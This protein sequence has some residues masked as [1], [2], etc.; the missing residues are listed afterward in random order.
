[1]LEAIESQL[2]DLLKKA[3]VTGEVEFSKPPKS[4]M[5]D[6][7]FV[8]FGL[9]KNPKEEAEKLAKVLKID[10]LELIDEVKAFGPYVNFFFN[11]GELACLTL[12]EASKKEYGSNNSGKDKKVLIEYPSQNTHKEFHIGH[13]RNVCIGNPLVQ[14]YRKS[15]YK[16]I[17]INYVND[18]GRHVVKALW[19]IQKFDKKP[20]GNKQKWLGEI[21]AEASKHIEENKE[22]VTPELDELQTKLEAREPETM[23]L[24]EETKS[25]SVGGFKNLMDELDVE[26][27]SIIYE[28]EVKDRGQEIVDEL[29]EKNIAEVGERGAIIIDLEKYNLGIAVLRKSTGGGLYH[30]SDLALAEKKFKKY[31]V[32]ESINITGT[33]QNHYFK[34]LFKIL[35][36]NGFKHKMTHIGYGLVNLPSGK[37]SSRAGNVILYEDLR[38]EVFASLKKETAERHADWSEE[39]INKTVH[40]LTMA[41]LKFTMQKHESN[42][43]I[44]FDMEEAM[45]F[46]GYSAP[47][48]LYATARINSLLRKGG[49]AKKINTALLKEAEEKKLLM[50]LGEYGE[51]VE[52]ALENYNPSTVARYCFELAQAFN[53]FYNKHSILNV[54]DKDLVSIRL[55]L[56]GAVGQVITDSLGLLTIETVEEM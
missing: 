53:D 52:K 51:V 39:K 9:G 31:K 19:Y 41:V 11:A 38:D 45:S 12:E 5:G 32:E 36:L 17:P 30:T 50:L 15:G 35:E 46:D 54:E 7:A 8:C 55:A 27:D 28:S 56:S 3:G 16:V 10:S 34:Q 33:E 26:H 23:K 2:K 1:M 42:K 14:F 20:K 40:T 48:I 43:I 22:E 25:W 44:T 4:D 21:Y 18:F 47:Y 29:L 13:F 6:V 49:K 37:M 24:F